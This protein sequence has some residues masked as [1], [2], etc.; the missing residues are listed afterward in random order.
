MNYALKLGESL[1]HLNNLYHQTCKKFI[2]YY[3]AVGADVS[4]YVKGIELY[5]LGGLGIPVSNR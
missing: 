4:Q 1:V 5:N 2:V 3:Y